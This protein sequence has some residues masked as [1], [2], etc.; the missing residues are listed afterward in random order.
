MLLYILNNILTPYR[1]HSNAHCGIN[2]Y[3]LIYKEAKLRYISQ[4]I[5]EKQRF[6]LHVRTRVNEQI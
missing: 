6:P 4:Q 5:M 1:Q 3:I 2:I